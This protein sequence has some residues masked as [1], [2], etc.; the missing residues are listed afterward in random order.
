MTELCMLGRKPEMLLYIRDTFETDA[1]QGQI[2]TED[3]AAVKDEA[4]AEACIQALFQ[5]G[6]LRHVPH[7]KTSLLSNP[8]K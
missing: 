5:H 1:T 8:R 4:L 7:P 6:S 3:E 2:V